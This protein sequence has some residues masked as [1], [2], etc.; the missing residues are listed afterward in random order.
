VYNRAMAIPDDLNPTA[1][2]DPTLAPRES[3]PPEGAAGPGPLPSPLLWHPAG[4][5]ANSRRF[6]WE[7]W[8]YINQKYVQITRHQGCGMESG[9]EQALDAARRPYS[10]EAWAGLR[11]RDRIDAIYRELRRIDAEHARARRQQSPGTISP[12]QT[13][14]AAEG[15]SV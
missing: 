13:N 6:H 3:A 2:P 8:H 14:V 10:G 12:E 9:F 7:N 1:R 4:P 5:I 11:P 15:A